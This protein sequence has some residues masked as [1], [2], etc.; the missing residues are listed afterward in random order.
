M[1]I[2]SSENYCEVS[3][4][5]DKAAKAI[6]GSVQ[7]SLRD[8]GRC[9]LMLT[10]GRSAAQVYE[11]LAKC[12]DFQQMA[13]VTFCFGDER[14]VPPSSLESNYG[15]VMRTLFSAGVPKGCTVLRMEADGMDLESASDRYSNAIP[16]HIDVLL[17]GV[18][19]DG[20]IASLFPYSEALGETR[21]RVVPVVG[22]RLPYRRL[23]ITPPVIRQA[24]SVYILA[25]GD[26]K[27]EV[28][29]R[30]RLVSGSIDS[31][32]ARL[33]SGAIWLLGADNGEWVE[34]QTEK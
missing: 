32:P 9:S 15:M 7:V 8:T 13:G 26:A 25:A 6:L 2:P 14:C 4:W 18:G 24:Q 12:P 10:G 34:Q 11:V 22:P 20:H 5:A 3:Q 29:D 23:T 17:L 16:E 21:R 19:E 27:V 30:A 33:V 1:L 31:F 28:F